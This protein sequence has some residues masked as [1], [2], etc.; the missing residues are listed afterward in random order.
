MIV[1]AEGHREIVLPS[2]NIV[3]V[4]PRR[5]V[6]KI[7]SYPLLWRPPKDCMGV[8]GHS[9]EDI[10]NRGVNIGVNTGSETV[11]NVDA[12]IRVGKLER[13]DHGSS[14]SMGKPCSQRLRG[15]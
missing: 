5:G 1:I 15:L 6:P 10:R 13:V 11:S 14:E 4:V 12:I 7:V 2:E 8:A 3:G 9:G